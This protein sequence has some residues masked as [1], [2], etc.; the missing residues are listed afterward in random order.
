MADNAQAPTSALVIDPN[1]TSRSILCAQLRDLGMSS[2]LQCGRIADAR[3]QL[4]SRHF[5]VVLCEMD[6]P[7]GGSSG[8]ELLEDLRRQQ[9]LPL[10]TVFVMVTGEASYA[11]VAEA[12]EAALD[13]YLLKPCSATALADRL[14]QAHARKRSLS[15]IFTAI[16]EERLE[17]AASLCTQ[18]FD[19]RGPYWT[20]AA[21]IGGELMLRLRR[22]GEA[23]QMFEAIAQ[24]QALPWARL[25][26]ARAQVEGGDAA[27]ALR[28]LE[29]LISDQPTFADAYDVM[30]RVQLEQGRFDE[31][32]T[33]YRRAAEL[34]PGSIGR[35][36]KFGMLAFY[37]GDCEAAVRSLERA[38]IVGQKSRQ[39]DLQSIVLLAFGHF[40]LNDS[41]GLQR[42]VMDL[43][44]ALERA[45]SSGRLQRFIAVVGV[46]QSM[47][48]KQIASVIAQIRELAG[49]IGQ[50]SFD[51]EAACNLLG[52][53]AE[54]VAAEL[55]LPGADDWIETLARRF[56]TAKGITELLLRTAHRH[57]PFGQLVQNCHAEI[58]TLAANAMMHTV[59]GQPSR[60]VQALLAHA[61]RTSN[62]K[63][64]ETANGVLQRYAAKIDDGDALKARVAAM[65][66]QLGQ[67]P[68][69]P[70]LGSATGRPE[71]GLSFGGKI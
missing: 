7:G 12:A 37:A 40:R 11:R 3:R 46:L 22:H 65:Q 61:E 36:Q 57:P 47:Q 51:L 25:G 15:A 29:S 39:L 17:D 31:A 34:T 53:I 60:A 64:V 43:Q 4:E 32:L 45:P 55:N 18:R 1:Q 58:G 42:S 2:V 70:P 41:K 68:R 10:A 50:P 13:S 49:E 21:R 23:Q 19:E 16:D 30:G 59:E 71:G 66:Q 28:T 67:T 44:R 24:T 35:L 26:I 33:I 8:R 27:P 5:D 6:F 52:L 9:M 54:L 63:F 48:Q 69:L 38:A 20:Y 62:L 56:C 14:R